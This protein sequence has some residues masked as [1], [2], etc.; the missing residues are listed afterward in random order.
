[1][2]EH[3]SVLVQELRRRS[4]RAVLSILSPASDP[5]RRHLAELFERPAGEP[6]SF[7]ADPVIEATFGWKAA[8]QTMA[9]LSGGLLDPRLV[10]AMDSVP[11]ELAEYRFPRDRRPYAHQVESWEALRQ[12][13]RSLV[14][15]SGT[16]SGKTE[17]FLVPILDSLVRE[18][19]TH[20]RLTGVRA[21]FL[22][23]LNALI[24]S[25]KDRLQAWTAREEG[26]V[27][28][29][30]YNGETPERVPAREQAA[31]PS[32]VLSRD[33]LRSEPPPILVTNSTMLEYMLVRKEDEPIIAASRGMLRWVVLDEA[34][35][36][37]G[38]NAADIA[39]LLRRVLHAFGV[40]PA[41]VHFVATSATISAVGG[42]RGRDELRRFLADIAGVDQ[43]AVSVLEGARYLPPLPGIAAGDGKPF[44]S[45][46]ELRQMSAGG[47]YGALSGYARIRALR[48][49]LATSG[50]ATLRQVAG[51][52]H[53]KEEADVTCEER[54]SALAYID[55]VRT[56]EKDGQ[57]LLPVRLHVFERTQKG[58]WACANASC[59]GREGTALADARW[60]WGKTYLDRQ[61]V[62]DAEGCGSLVLELLLCAECG[63]EALLG[64][65]VTREEGRRA[66]EPVMSSDV[67]EQ[68]GEL[69]EPLLAETTDED[70]VAEAVHPSQFSAPRLLWSR[71][72][73]GT[74]ATNVDLRTGQIVTA[75]EGAAMHV[76]LPVNDRVRC[77]RC[78]QSS[79]AL[80][81][82]FRPA[83]TG[84]PSLLGVALPT[85][86]E[87]SPAPGHTDP[88]PLEGRRILT[89]SDS[90][91][92]TARFALKAQLDAERNFGRSLIYH[93]VL[94]NRVPRGQGGPAELE[95]QIEALR[96]SNNP[97]LRPLIHQ[98]EQQVAA[99]R[100]PPPPSLSWLAAEEAF[101]R[102][103]EVEQW[104]R[105]AWMHLPLGTMAQGH[106]GSFL[107]FR[108]FLRRPKRQFSLET[109][110]LVAL[111]YRR[112]E[113][114][115]EA[116][117]PA[118]WRAMGRTIQQWR[119]LLT[120]IVNYFVRGRG[121]VQVNELFLR[122]MGSPARQRYLL[123]PGDTVTNRYTQVRW[124][125]MGAGG[126]VTQIPDLLC[127]GLRLDP[128]AT[129]TRQTVNDLLVAAWE[130]L[131]P[132]MR[133]SQ[134]GYQ[135]DV[136]NEADL[137]AC[138]RAYF[139]PVTR[140]LLDATCE[141]IT[142]YRVAGGGD[143]LA[144]CRAV[145]VPRH[146]YPFGKTETGGKVE[147][148]EI[149]EWLEW[150]E[151][152]RSL[153]ALGAWNEFTDRIF[154]FQGY[155][156][157]S[158]HSA[159]MDSSRLRGIEKSFKDGYV[160]LLSC[161]TT[162]EMGVDI[163][164]LTSVGMTNVPP[165]PANYLQRAGRAGRRGESASSTLTICP[166]VPH[167]EA[168]FA[169]PLWPFRTAVRSPYVSLDSSRIVQRH[170]NA[171]ALREFLRGISANSVKLKAG[172]F[173]EASGDGLVAPAEEFLARLTDG[174]LAGPGGVAE[175][176]L[177]LVQRSALQG[178]S[179]T[180]I[181][182]STARDL[183]QLLANY[184]A[185]LQALVD[186]M[187]QVRGGGDTENAPA[188]KAIEIQME[189]LRDEFLLRDLTARGFLPGHGFPTDLVPFINTT[190]EL[191]D[192]QTQQRQRDEVRSRWKGFPT[193]DTTLALREYAP[194]AEIV[195]D[196]QVFES[197][198]VSLIWKAPPDDGAAREIQSFLVAWRCRSCG[199]A[200][201]ASNRPTQC[202]EC[203]R[204]EDSLR[205]KPFLRP[206]GFAVDLA[207][208]THNDVSRRRYIPVRDPWVSAR[209]GE[210]THLPNGTRGRFR[211][212]PEGLVFVHS[213]GEK[214]HGYAI[215]LNCGRSA[216]E[217]GPER[218]HPARPPQLENPDS[219]GHRR[220]RGGRSRSQSGMCQGTSTAWGVKRHQAL[221]LPVYTDIFEVQLVNPETM[222]GMPDRATAVSV[223]IALGRAL[224]ENLGID[225]REL[226]CTGIPS[227]GPG[228]DPQFSAIVYDMAPGGAG[229][230]AGIRNALGSLLRRAKSILECP[231]GCDRACHA[232][233][234]TYASQFQVDLLDR[235][236]ALECLSEDFL[237]GLDL[238]VSLRLLGDESVFEHDSALQALRRELQRT[239]LTE[240]HLFLAGHSA[241]WDIAAWNARPDLMRWCASGLKCTLV[242]PDR[243]LGSLS[244]EVSGVLA[245]L[246]EAT[247]ASLL[248]ASGRE[249]YPASPGV[250]AELGG[251]KRRI[252]WATNDDRART[253]NDLWGSRGNGA[254]LVRCED[255]V[256][257]PQPNLGRAVPPEELR[258]RNETHTEIKVRTEL[259]GA[260][261]G[262]GRRFWSLL[263]RGVP[264]LRARLSNGELASVSYTDRYIQS[265]WTVRLTAELLRGLSAYSAFS[266]TKTVV[267]IRTVR[268]GGRPGYSTL[269]VRDDWPASPERKAVTEGVLRSLGERISLEMHER[270]AVEHFR[271]VSLKWAD[272]SS[273]HVRLDQGVG[274][275]EP[276]GAIPFSF[277]ADA[278]SQLRLLSALK[279]EARASGSTVLYAGRT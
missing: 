127:R 237:A 49:S 36:Y 5:L 24:A 144:L 269:T 212:D 272:G 141:N 80:E 176:L 1:M 100:D 199:A 11:A 256:T 218:D 191:L 249:P 182:S 278:D 114:L 43:D 40:S 189:R 55:L 81:D 96:S 232:C 21:L 203:E 150:D 99:L 178:V 128:N 165:S 15:S 93:S 153:R 252:G 108:E 155:F 145:E 171:M 248:G 13:G 196:G 246:I 221:G 53:G 208:E 48:E 202:P 72:G 179:P 149:R 57:S 211:Y 112:I 4:A 230:S 174:R 62:C 74:I 239:D 26:R 10:A 67:D 115:S 66:I 243:L 185:E 97:V 219:G 177:R 22:Y 234:L 200:G 38:T 119:E 205:W 14:V 60:P 251:P 206:G 34:H 16:S 134:D 138:R 160:N 186:E 92:G 267:S 17:C 19:A 35:T 46:G 136:R 106:V 83:R 47:R 113:G 29:C 220:L 39:L 125:W 159:Q 44:P 270:R 20:G 94:A 120:I 91:Q 109:L 101:H 157:A 137:V 168:V 217:T 162:M 45:A 98:L 197:G 242:V 133:L 244:P 161:S 277:T 190:R 103:T 78:E 89:F 265:P 170:A 31:N 227:K 193:R 73:H 111:R 175:G 18:A 82:Q 76:G 50:P 84:A 3:F 163:G 51:V 129:E 271:E 187:E 28:S 173:F 247:S 12:E 122:W 56:A 77:I 152:V 225:D 140:R 61:T 194:G 68:E 223:A 188:R 42:K 65:E 71:E 260:I 257:A 274:F 245:S 228:G 224:A 148:R 213:L 85:L 235:H 158:E 30:L 139:C 207:Y 75:N 33:L 151:T 169:N 215:C 204:S 222:Q 198:G 264:G 121:A 102:S 2:T 259:D 118:A 226:G 104:M 275:L 166:G 233:L 241:D 27:R 240:I 255:A 236:K 69:D 70:E 52:L 95:Q 132:L 273:W 124:P 87:L 142:P 172:W 79:S 266:K 131:I 126:R 261:E 117:L 180:R 201:V 164:G 156:R 262:L 258:R 130:Q 123:A 37:L 32:L 167:S 216:S 8:E 54:E 105:R 146:P 195:I 9:E 231:R 107:L 88:R 116:S 7:L 263:E 86:L 59:S 63:A 238:P 143:E 181:L 209:H 184:R 147:P 154:Q 250:V 90:R 23:P 192:Q 135:L 253:P 268:G 110:G 6:G 210:W 254:A 229:F 214:G 279:A 276:V 41:S 25:Q 64:R 58:V 183:A